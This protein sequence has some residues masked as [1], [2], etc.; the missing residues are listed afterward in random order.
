M[1]IMSIVMIMG[2]LVKMMTMRMIR[3]K[4]MMRVITV[5]IMQM[6]LIVAERRMT[7]RVT[8]VMQRAQR[9]D[10]YLVLVASC[11]IYGGIEINT[12]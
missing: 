3:V 6:D 10:T 8:Q 12:I 5:M 11:A 9:Q 7:V 4:M 1:T 2:M